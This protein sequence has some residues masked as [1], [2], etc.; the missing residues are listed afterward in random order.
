MDDETKQMLV[1]FLMQDEILPIVLDEIATERDKLYQEH[2]RPESTES[3]LFWIRVAAADNVLQE[4]GFEAGEFAFSE[5]AL[6]QP[7][8]TFI[9]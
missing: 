7:L 9:N 2:A 5:Y 4:W 8:N 6:G 3:D 1:R